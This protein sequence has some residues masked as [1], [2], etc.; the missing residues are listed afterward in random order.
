MAPAFTS[1]SVFYQMSHHSHFSA[2]VT[3]PW[4]SLAWSSHWWTIQDQACCSRSHAPNAAETDKNCGTTLSVKS[5]LMVSFFL[6]QGRWLHTSLKTSIPRAS[7]CWMFI[8]I[9]LFSINIFFDNF[10][11]L[12]QILNIF[13]AFIQTRCISG[14]D[15]LFTSDLFKCLF[16]SLA[17]CRL[18]ILPLPLV[19]CQSWEPQ[20]YLEV[21]ELLEQ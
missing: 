15:S 21:L 4:K 7:A 5:S 6:W 12:K 19:L 2:C 17:R 16:S 10:L 1:H 9:S 11:H 3:Y 8:Y 14:Y 13:F 18:I 20:A